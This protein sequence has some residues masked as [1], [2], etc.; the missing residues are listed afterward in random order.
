MVD[1]LMALLFV[2]GCHDTN[3]ITY[4]STCKLINWY[5]GK[6]SSDK[7]VKVRD[8]RTWRRGRVTL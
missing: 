3:T 7:E 2:V 5:N 1:M 4:E 8:R 6:C